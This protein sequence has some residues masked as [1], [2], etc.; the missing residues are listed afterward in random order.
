MEKPTIKEI[1][2]KYN[3]SS[4]DT[5][6]ARIVCR[7]FSV[8]FSWVFA[9]FPITPNQISLLMI[10]SGIIGGIFLT[11]QSYLNGLIGVLF[12]QLFLVLDCV[13]GEV[14]RIKKRFSSKG[15]FL[16]LLANDII[17]VSIFAGLTFR[18]F[19]LF[20][21]FIV[22]IAGFCAIVFFLLS[23][24]FPFYAKEAD[25]KL[26]GRYLSPVIFNTKLKLI[27][28]QIIKNFTFPPT[29]IVI[30]TVG[31]I[32]NV[33]QYIL[34]FYGIFFIFYYFVSLILRLKKKL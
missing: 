23:K 1:R 26:T 17:F 4:S 21:N 10:L 19:L 13:D 2:D 27:V 32:F 34:Y 3:Y 18:V 12:L 22:I 30:I 11:M 15:K 7:K 31:A 33:F 28:F 16:D 20:E 29:I 9:R 8:Y 5:W 25:E 6:Y 24:L 14:A